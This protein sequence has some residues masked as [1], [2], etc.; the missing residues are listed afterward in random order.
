MG[1]V[2]KAASCSTKTAGLRRLP[3]SAGQAAYVV[4]GP[5]R[6]PG[7]RTVR[8]LMTPGRHR[9]EKADS[10]DRL[11]DRLKAGSQFWSQF[12]A[13]FAE[14]KVALTSRSQ[15]WAQFR[16]QVV[17]GSCGSWLDCGMNWTGS[18]RT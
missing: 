2:A 7:S 16:S 15:F 6:V 12:R 3:P 8:Q 11:K 18:G 17:T 4:S 9:L 10:E 14:E 1:R 13:Q 5:D